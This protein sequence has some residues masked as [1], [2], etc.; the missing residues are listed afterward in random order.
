MAVPERVAWGRVPVGW[1][2]RQGKEKQ[3]QAEG[4]DRAKREGTG[5]G[6][7]QRMTYDFIGLSVRC[8]WGN[9][10]GDTAAT[11]GPCL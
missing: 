7:G 11:T 3:Y 8:L 4:R 1:F 6:C 5:R 2:I 10:G 9:R